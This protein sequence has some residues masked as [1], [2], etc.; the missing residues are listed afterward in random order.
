VLDC[1]GQ[2]GL[3]PGGRISDDRSL[4]E[5]SQARIGTRFVRLRAAFRPHRA[6]VEG[7]RYLG[8]VAYTSYT[9]HVFLEMYSKTVC[10]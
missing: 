9:C 5:R 2:G 1:S 3:R 4:G 8:E 6:S 7:T 10:P